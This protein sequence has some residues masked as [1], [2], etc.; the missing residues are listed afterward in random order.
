MFLVGPFLFSLNLAALPSPPSA[1]EFC[2]K[3]KRGRRKRRR[4]KAKKKK[5][6]KIHNVNND[7]NHTNDFNLVNKD[8]QI[9]F[10]CWIL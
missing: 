6:D 2:K 5:V 1:V 9:S 3:E 8:F 4:R 7:F 10:G